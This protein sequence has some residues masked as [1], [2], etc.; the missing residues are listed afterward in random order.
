[1]RIV[2]GLVAIVPAGC[3]DQTANELKRCVKELGFKAGHLV[4]YCGPRNLN[5]PSFF[6]YYELP[7][8]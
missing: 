5:D 6:P 4:Q 3:P 2:F 8:S 1:M 7:S